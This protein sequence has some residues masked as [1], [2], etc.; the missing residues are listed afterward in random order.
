MNASEIADALTEQ[1]VELA[2]LQARYD[3][4]LERNTELHDRLTVAERQAQSFYDVDKA[5]D[6]MTPRLA[7]WLYKHCAT[8]EVVRSINHEP[9]VRIKNPAGRVLGKAKID[10]AFPTEYCAFA[11]A[12]R[13]GM[14]KHA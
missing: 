4:L 14:E 6:T 8:I 9:F 13:A 3:A 12:T 2:D 11:T 7:R 5:I 10:P 1:V